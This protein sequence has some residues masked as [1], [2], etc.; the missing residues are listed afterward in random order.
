MEH[1]PFICVVI[2]SIPFLT[3]LA[4]QLYNG[5]IATTPVPQVP[6]EIKAYIAY[7]CQA[8]FVIS[9]FLIT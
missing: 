6:Y 7:T 2:E 5:Y 4:I 9:T 8:G 3:D 1:I